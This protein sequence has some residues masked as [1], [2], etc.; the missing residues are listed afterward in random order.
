VR[1]E[2]EEDMSARGLL[3]EVRVVDLT[4]GA[5]NL[6]SRLLADLGADVLLIEPPA[7]L[8][9]RG[10]APVHDGVSL[11]FAMHNANKRSVVLDLATDAGRRGLRDV[12]VAADIVIQSG[13]PGALPVSG[14]ELAEIRQLNAS[15]VLVSV[16]DFGP[17]GPSADERASAWTLLARSAILA[18]SGPPGVNCPPLMPPTVVVEAI[19]A[20]QV[21]WAALVGY[22]TALSSGLGDDIEVSAFEAVLQ[23]FDPVFG[24]G[25]TAGAGQR[26]Y[27]F[28]AGRP[29]SGHLYPIFACREG[30]VR[31]AVLGVR[32]WHGLRGWI[33]DPDEF[34]D[35]S[36]DLVMNR[37]RAAATLYPLIQSLFADQD[38]A[39][40]VAEGQRRGVPI[41]PVLSPSDVIAAGHYRERGAI[42]ELEIVPGL[43]AAAPTGCFEVD[44]ER[45]GFRDRAPMVGEA[46]TVSWDSRQQP[47]MSSLDSRGPLAGLRIIDLGVIVLGA[48]VGR[49]FADLG[50]EVIKV[51]SRG[52]PDAGRTAAGTEMTPSFAWGNRNKLGLG[53]NLR[54]AAGI[55]LFKQLAASSDLVLANFKPGTM[56]SLGIGFQDLTTVNKRI[57]VANSSAL[58]ATGPW[59]TWM[60]YGPLV[61]AAAGLTSLWRSPD[62]PHSFSD[63]STV[64]PD[65]YAARIA[66][67]GALAGLIDARRSG[68]GHLVET[69]QAET[70]LSAFAPRY[71]AESLSPGSFEPEGNRGPHDA[72][73]GVFRCDGDDQW[74]V[75]TARGDDDWARLTT[76]IGVPELTADPQF[77]TPEARAHHHEALVE[78]IEAWTSARPAAEAVASLLASGIAAAVMATPADIADDPQ[79]LARGYWDMLIQPGVPEPLPTEA[80][81]FTSRL[82]ISDPKRPAPLH[83]QHTRAICTDLLG[84]S[85]TQVDSLLADGTLEDTDPW[86]PVRRAKR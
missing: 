63:T 39:D 85:G 84:L 42:A 37:F 1:T 64:F 52:F 2:E 58:G 48:E 74:C 57:V 19:V 62:D 30:H 80:R 49:L 6:G 45:A 15:L 53:L 44:G 75:V 41:A 28:A 31:I 32:Q 35:T 86:R 36:Y 70:I 17:D 68:R 27:E 71:A 5:V 65:H 40:L 47:A 59:R 51:E 38:A 34:M 46:G 26:W 9:H 14:V 23:Q 13:L 50:A 4:D 77:G 22:W 11:R 24:T 7:G 54:T 66:A 72:T 61:R 76:A 56:E 83:G 43:T 60:G 10:S 8:S 82:L 79:L 73:C 33:G 81:P 55:G 69:S 20:A 12:L 67:I 29:D 21:G 25:G 78:I 16:T 3:A 18:R